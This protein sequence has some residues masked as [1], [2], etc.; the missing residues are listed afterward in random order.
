MKSVILATNAKAAAIPD[1]YLDTVTKT[2]NTF[3]GLALRSKKEDGK[4]VFRCSHYPGTVKAQDIKDFIAANFEVPMLIVLGKH[5][6]ELAKDDMQPFVLFEKDGVPELVCAIEGDGFTEQFAPSGSA[7]TPPFFVATTHLIPMLQGSLDMHERSFKK[8]WE[9]LQNPMINNSLKN[10]PKGGDGAIVMMRD[11]GHL[12]AFSKRGGA[13]PFGWTSNLMGMDF[14]TKVEGV[15][16]TAATPTKFG[17][18]LSSAAS[19]VANVMAPKEPV[20][21]P[22]EDDPIVIPKETPA[23][24]VPDGEVEISPPLEYN[25]QMA[26]DFYRA[27]IGKAAQLPAGWKDKP[28]PTIRVKK[29][30]LRPEHIKLLSGLVG[31]SVLMQKPAAPKA[32]AIKDFKDIP[33]PV[34]KPAVE[35]KM[36]LNDLETENMLTVIAGP[37]FQKHV[38]AQGELIKDPKKWAEAE[39]K[40]PSFTEQMGLTTDDIYTWPADAL[41]IFVKGFPKGAK[42]LI[43]ELRRKLAFA[44]AAIPKDVKVKDIV[45]SKVEAPAPVKTIAPPVASDEDEDDAPI[46]IKAM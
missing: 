7:H 29:S 20:V 19:A 15:H 1:A 8:L 45:N 13:T 4:V 22:P 18:M 41:D 39:E 37:V 44:Q 24:A 6:G 16:A 11:T 35:D 43:I 25:Q 34:T 2:F 10:L 32:E 40:Y 12:L 27:Y 3:A 5:T 28:R 38:I 36:I 17:S 21:A 31:P 33:A 14:G 23:V 42:L 46:L 26:K 30:A 9:D